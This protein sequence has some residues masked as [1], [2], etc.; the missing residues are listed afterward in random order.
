MSPSTRQASLR[1]RHSLGLAV[2]IAAGSLVA[3]CGKHEAAP[4]I[5]GEVNNEYVTTDEFLHQIKTRGGADLRGQT[6]EDF[7]QWLLAELVDRKLLLQEARRCSIRPN[8]DDVRI[9]IKEMGARGWEDAERAQVL[10]VEDDLWE[11]AQIDGLLRRELPPIR[12]PSAREVKAYVQ[13]HPEVFARPAQFLLRQIVVHSAAMVDKAEAMLMD[14]ETF[15]ETAVRL[16]GRQRVSALGPSWM[17]QDDVPPEVW[18]AAVGARWRRIVG[19]VASEYG[20]H[21]FRVE[22]RR[23]A[24]PVEPEVA[25]IRA[26]KRIVQERRQKLVE[27]LLARVRRGAV[28][29]IDRAAV[30]A[31]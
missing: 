7:K 8:R 11:Q 16:G 25:T 22:G 15:E 17:G 6:R 27:A 21:L 26:R 19:P 5:L 29:K 23:E 18:A 13:A 28:I 24:G 30:A 20:F 4:E 12:N 1:A 2:V 31:L 9:R 3:G 14:G 10:N